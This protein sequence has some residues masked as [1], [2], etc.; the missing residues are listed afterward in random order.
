MVKFV[1][2][3]YAASEREHESLDQWRTQIVLISR[4]ITVFDEQHTI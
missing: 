3:G 4:E 2:I 1:G